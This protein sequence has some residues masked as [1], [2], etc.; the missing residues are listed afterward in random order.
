MTIIKLK[1]HENRFIKAINPIHY[2]FME[3]Q[4]S[5]GRDEGDNCLVEQLAA[6]GK[7]FWRP[8]LKK[9]SLCF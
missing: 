6:N 3:L 2:H 5:D 7:L 4:Y 9:K 8:R 1:F